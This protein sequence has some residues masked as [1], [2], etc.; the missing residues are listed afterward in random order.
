MISF[1]DFKENEAKKKELSALRSKYEIDALEGG[2]LT[3]QFKK[4]PLH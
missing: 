4:T 2:K 3:V 1:K